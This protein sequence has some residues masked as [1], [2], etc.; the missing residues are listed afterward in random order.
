MITSLPDDCT[1]STISSPS[2]R[3][4]NRRPARVEGSLN[5]WIAKRKPYPFDDIASA[6]VLGIASSG[7][8]A[9]PMSVTHRGSS[10]KAVRTRSPSL[11]RKRRWIGSPKPR[12]DE[13]MSLMRMVYAVPKLEKKTTEQRVLPP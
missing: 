11:K 9:E 4:A 6:C 2:L 12:G 10:E 1:T 13:G 8:F 3:R 7:S 5:G